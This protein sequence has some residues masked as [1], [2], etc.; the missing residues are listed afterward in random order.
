MPTRA[1]VTVGAAAGTGGT[2]TLDSGANDTRGQVTVTSGASGAGAGLLATVALVGSWQNY[3]GGGPYPLV[4]LN[5]DNVHAAA[6]GTVSIVL[7]PFGMS[8]L[9]YCT[10]TPTASTAYRINYLLTH[11]PGA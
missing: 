1:T 11:G 9:I 2:A 3:K 5:E 6:L 4:T 7:G 10:G 8:V